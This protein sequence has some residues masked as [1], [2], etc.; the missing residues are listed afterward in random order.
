MRNFLL[1]VTRSPTPER[2]E[3]C[4]VFAPHGRQVFNTLELL[5]GININR[6]REAINNPMALNIS[7][8]FAL[9][10]F[11]NVTL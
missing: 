4:R 2:L 5:K 7:D 6:A 10:Q 1:I 3:V 11:F 8:G 9:D